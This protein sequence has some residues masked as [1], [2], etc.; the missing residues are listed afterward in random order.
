MCPECGTDFKPS[1]YT[2]APNKVCFCCPHC[3]QEYYGQDARGHPQPQ[4]F[5]CVKCSERIHLDEMVLRPAADVSEEETMPPLLPWA[6]RK[7]GVVGDWWRTCWMALIRP[8]VL[9]DRVLQYGA[10]TR[11]LSFF[12]VTQLLIYGSFF[13]FFCVIFGLFTIAMMPGPNIL[14][15][16]LLLILYLGFIFILL[17]IYAVI[18]ALVTHLVLK[19]T[20]TVAKPLGHTINLLFYSSGAN[21]ATIVPCLGWYFGWL[22]WLVSAIIMLRVGQQVAAW[23]AVLAGL[24]LPVI[25]M[26]IMIVLYSG[27]I[28]MTAFQPGLTPMAGRQMPPNLAVDMMNHELGSYRARNR[29]ELPDHAA[30]LL[31]GDSVS[32]EHFLPRGSTQTTL[33]VRV[34]GYTLDALNAMSTD[35]K[36]AAIDLAA[37]RLP[38]DVIA[39]RLGAFVFTYHGIDPADADANLWL[40]V[41]V[42]DDSTLVHLLQRD[43]RTRAVVPA[44][45]ENHLEDQNRLRRRHGLPSLTDPRDVTHDQPMRPTSD[46]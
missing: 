36:R 2:F 21:I 22:W 31:M 15:V 29:N 16:G 26:V 6:D 42:D 20:G 23:R 19:M 38:E 1:Q 45:F 4:S 25:S 39:H 41:L 46:D 17:L 35:E 13:A 12:S 34:G 11:A 27:A 37:E 32:P 28:A 10:K 24:A 30:R 5:D 9:G 3:G 7:G 43:G 40:A 8:H 18:G 33:D 44:D 14:F